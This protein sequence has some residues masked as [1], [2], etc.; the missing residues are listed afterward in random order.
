MGQQLGSWVDCKGQQCEVAH[1]HAGKIDHHP[2]QVHDFLKVDNL[3][4]RKLE[5]TC[6]RTKTLT[7]SPLSVAS[8][9][10]FTAWEQGPLETTST[11]CRS[12]HEE[13]VEQHATIVDNNLSMVPIKRHKEINNIEIN[14]PLIILME[15][16][17]Y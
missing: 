17:D 9:L 7:C 3:E 11:L 2:H 8:G 1:T 5:T 4:N 10:L 15:H 12:S 14:T 16:K 13:G 6:T